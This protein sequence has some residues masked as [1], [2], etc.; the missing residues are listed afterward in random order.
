MR[1]GM[2]GGL[3]VF[4]SQ[5]KKQQL[6][7]SYIIQMQSNSCGNMHTYTHAAAIKSSGHHN[8]RAAAAPATAGAYYSACSSSPAAAAAA[9]DD[10]DAAPAAALS[11]A[12]SALQNALCSGH[13]R[14]AQSEPQ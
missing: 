5:N 10:D 7:P 14:L 2:R 3:A 11:R 9:V 1:A 13:A 8:T 12:A 6:G 4:V